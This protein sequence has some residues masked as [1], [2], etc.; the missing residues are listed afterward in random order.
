MKKNRLLFFLFF[1]T[2][3]AAIVSGEVFVFHTVS[4]CRV[5]V[6]GRTFQPGEALAVAVEGNASMKKAAVHFM[7]KKYPMFSA[8]QPEEFITVIGLDIGVPAGSH[9]LRVRIDYHNG[10]VEMANSR[11]VVKEKQFP[12]KELWVDEDYVTPPSEQTAR[13]RRESRLLQSL[14]K[15]WT[16]D[17]LG[18]GNFMLPVNGEAFPNFGER[19]IF[20]NKP[21][22]SHSGVDISA[23]TGT[24]VAASNSG[25]VVLAEDLYFAGNTV[26]IDHGLGIFSL[27]CHFSEILVD[28]G[29]DIGK[30]DLIGK[31]GATGR[32][33]G[34]HLHWG[35]KI[36]GDRVDPF[37][38][39]ELGLERKGTKPPAL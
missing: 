32:V 37:S 36:Q 20:N 1:L 16:E 31:I 3:A 24:P 34:P 12:V 15:Q 22:S 23:T 9:P 35:I 6:S 39:L 27:Y 38:L 8:G 29:S 4:G 19:R 25:R 5:E 28:K 14:Y 10:S 18:D 13:I 17:W 7:E 26:I 11:I 2:A 30:G 21:R 33:T